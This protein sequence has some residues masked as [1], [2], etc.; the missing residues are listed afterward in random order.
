[1]S[2]TGLV[3]ALVAG[4]ALGYAVEEG[5]RLGSGRRFR[6]VGRAQ[7]VRRVFGSVGVAVLMLL[8]YAGLDLVD[9]HRAPRNYMVLWSVASLLTL[10]LVALAVLDLRDLRRNRAREEGRF[11]VHLRREE[12]GKGDAGE[13]RADR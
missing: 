9:P 11:R 2:G 4:L 6:L 10:L 12:S 3:C 13:R 7:A 5:R 8:V 1:V